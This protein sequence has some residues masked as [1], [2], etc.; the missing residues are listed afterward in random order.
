MSSAR[1]ASPFPGI[2]MTRPHFHPRSLV[3]QISEWLHRQIR[4]GIWKEF[5]PSERVLVERLGASRPVVRRAIHRLAAEGILEIKPGTPARVVAQVKRSSKT[6]RGKR[7]VLLYGDDAASSISLW[8]MMAIDALRKTLYGNGYQFDIIPDERLRRRRSVSYLDRLVEQHP[9]EF[10]I[11]ASMSAEVLRWFQRRGLQAV[12]MGSSF[13]GIDF[14]SVNDDLQGTSRHAAGVFLSLGHE[15][16]V[17]LQRRTGSAGE[18]IEENGFLEA[19]APH[20]HLAP[21]VVRHDGSVGQVRQRLARI[22]GAAAP[23]TAMLV[24]HAMDLL[25]VHDWLLEQR[26][27]V[28][29]QVSLISFQWEP[30]LER[31]NPLPA[32]YYS[33]PLLHARHLARRIIQNR[34]D[35]ESVRLAPVF[36]RNASVAPPPGRLLPRKA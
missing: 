23:P 35:T 2:F 22:F 17:Y 8:P 14:L 33:D 24:S 11:L 32:W 15:R 36:F 29:G 21:K 13:P 5:L 16:V 9:A 3:E 1:K 19:F 4:D 26:I 18:I 28:P 30:Y 6:G 31:I 10:W 27:A 20:P 34:R 7:V 12:V 25:V